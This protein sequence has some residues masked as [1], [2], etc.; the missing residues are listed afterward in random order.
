MKRILIDTSIII[1]CLRQKNKRQTVFVKL[2]QDQTVLFTSIVTHTECFSG[3][4]IWERKEAMEA[5]KLLFSD[6]KI[7]LLDEKTSEKAGGIRAQYSRNL[8]DAIIAATALTY[9]L[10]LATLNKKDFE[11]IDGINLYEA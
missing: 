11:K 9:K 1:D 7:L 6:I 2:V 4:S 3:K 5:L 8:A 10:E